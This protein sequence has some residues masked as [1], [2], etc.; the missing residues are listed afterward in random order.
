MSCMYLNVPLILDKMVLNFE[1]SHKFY[2]FPG[3]DFSHDMRE[4]GK[5]AS[6]FCFAEHFF[7]RLWNLTRK[8]WNTMW[9]HSCK[10]PYQHSGLFI[11]WFWNLISTFLKY[12]KTMRNYSEI[13]E[14]RLEF[15][16]KI[17][18]LDMHFIWTDFYHQKV[19]LLFHVFSSYFIL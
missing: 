18:L 11:L 5:V 15:T 8:L 13:I 3:I 17:V 9:F 12:H 19:I 4:V 1:W 7:S 14:I 6:C 10:Y 2:L 16:L